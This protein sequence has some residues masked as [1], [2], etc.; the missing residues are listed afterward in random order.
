MKPNHLQCSYNLFKVLSMHPWNSSN[1]KIITRNYTVT[2]NGN[3]ASKTYYNN[4]VEQLQKNRISCNRRKVKTIDLLFFRLKVKTGLGVL[5][6]SLVSSWHK[7]PSRSKPQ[8]AW[9]WKINMLFS[10]LIYC[11]LPSDWIATTPDFVYIYCRYVVISNSYQRN[12][13]QINVKMKWCEQ[14]NYLVK[15]ACLRHIRTPFSTVKIKLWGLWWTIS[16]FQ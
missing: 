16:L 12:R 2:N 9:R 10:N 8:D 1:T 4:F 5:E 11:I 13:K 14:Y 3:C 6:G 15:I 7:A